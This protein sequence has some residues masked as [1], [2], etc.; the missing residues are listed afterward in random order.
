MKLRTCILGLASPSSCFHPRSIL[1][2][3]GNQSDH[4]SNCANQYLRFKCAAQGNLRWLTVPINVELSILLKDKTI[5]T[6]HL[7]AKCLA[8]G[9]TK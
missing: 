3:A 9:R 7:K 6:N 2:S 1:F 4:F 8:K 5:L